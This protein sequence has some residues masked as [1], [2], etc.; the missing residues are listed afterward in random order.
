M[1]E[2]RERRL[3]NT[4]REQR[5]KLLPTRHRRRRRE[6]TLL[7]V[8]ER[9]AQRVEKHREPRLQILQNVLVL[10][11]L[12]LLR[13]RR[14]VRGGGLLFAEFRGGRRGGRRR[15]AER[16]R[17]RR[18]RLDLLVQRERSADARQ[19]ALELLHCL[20]SGRRPVRLQQADAC[21][22]NI[23]VSIRMGWRQTNEKAGSQVCPVAR[24][25][26]EGT[27]RDGRQELQYCIL[28]YSPRAHS[29]ARN[30]EHR[31]IELER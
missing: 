19:L 28:H 25:V 17:L 12:V 16:R 1:C 9:V 18:Q 23:K 11:L 5:R 7:E 31:G 13:R 6:R 29:I 10:L 4:S 15:G 3:G 21:H 2:E 22:A 8:L 27:G 30:R 24:R 20:Q 26:L 14:R